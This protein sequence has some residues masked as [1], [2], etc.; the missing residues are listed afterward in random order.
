MDR[1]GAATIPA[2]LLLSIV[3]ELSPSDICFD[4]DSKNI[5][6]IQSGPTRYTING[7]PQE[8]FPPLGRIDQPKICK[9]AQKDLSDGLKKTFYAI[10]TD[11]GRYVLNGLLFS[12]KNNKLTLVATDGRRLA[13]ADLEVESRCSQ[14]IEVI[15]P[16]KAVAEL[17][18]LVR[19]EGEVKIAIGE[20]QISFE[21]NSA[22]LMSKLIE[23]TYPDY[24]AVIPGEPN[25]RITLEREAFLAAV[26]RT[27][28]LASSSTKLSFSKDKIEIMATTP[29][30]GEA[31][32]SLDVKY[33]GPKFS[34]S[35]NVEHLMAPLRNLSD[36]EIYLDLIDKTSP[37]VIKTEEPFLYVLVPVRPN[38]E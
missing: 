15:V 5:A 1:T 32:E 37:G 34:I 7:F 26:H 11:E 18:R 36:N 30:I 16:A 20:K 13:S 27:A 2:R 6:S 22:L 19:A 17:Q 38:S 29:A 12:L 33:K 31:H 21:L 25:E 24:S 35:F 14:G 9:I 23:G 28:L 4:V 10:S 8:E 3:R